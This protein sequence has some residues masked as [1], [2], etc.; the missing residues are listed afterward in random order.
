MYF[1]VQVVG[2][3]TFFASLLLMGVDTSIIP[4]ALIGVVVG[5]LFWMLGDLGGRI[6]RIEAALGAE[7]P[8]PLREALQQRAKLKR[9]Y[10]PA[11]SSEQG[12]HE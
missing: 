8:D 5:L 6:V 9:N 7:R 10:P 4:I 1:F 12:N 2:F 3:F 11:Q